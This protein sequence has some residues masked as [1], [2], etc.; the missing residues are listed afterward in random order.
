M[1]I[2]TGALQLGQL[3]VNGAW[4]WRLGLGFSWV[5]AG[6]GASR[7][8]HV[9]ITGVTL[10]AARRA[11]AQTWCDGNFGAGRVVIL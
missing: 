8:L 5:F 6:V 7:V 3:G 1:L 2:E 4:E 11:T 10:T 9:T